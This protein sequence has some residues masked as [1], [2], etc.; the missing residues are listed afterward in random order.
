MVSSSLMLNSK[1]SQSKFL[2]DYI[3]LEVKQEISNKP[4]D[5]RINQAPVPENINAYF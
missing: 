2:V 5:G 3:F 1:S 4:C